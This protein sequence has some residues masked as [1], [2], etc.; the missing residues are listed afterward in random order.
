MRPVPHRPGWWHGGSY[1]YEP[2]LPPGWLL[3]SFDVPSTAAATWAA[4]NAFD[5]SRVVI[6]LPEPLPMGDRA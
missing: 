2:E 6:E 1:S 4:V 3:V 5:G